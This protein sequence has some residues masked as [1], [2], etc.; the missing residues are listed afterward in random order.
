MGY[1]IKPIRPIVEILRLEEDFDSGTFGSL[2]LQ[3]KVFCWTLEPP[4][5]LN[6]KNKSSIPAQQYLCLRVNSPT[7]GETFQVMDVPGRTSVLFHPG[8]TIIDTQA[9]I[10]PGLQVGELAGRRAVLSSRAAFNG[11]MA[12]LAGYQS[13]HLTITNHF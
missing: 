1:L 3:K 7:Y 5:L 6:E 10:M 12:S 13:F 8:N 2:R 9:C 4:A 11:L